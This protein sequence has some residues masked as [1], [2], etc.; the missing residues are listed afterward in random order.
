MADPITDYY[1][2]NP[3]VSIN[4][5]TFD[6]YVPALLDTF[7]KR[8]VYRNFV[9]Y[10]IDLGAQR[11]KKM[12]FTELFD[13]EPNTNAV[14]L[15]TLWANASHLDSR[16]VSVD[17]EYHMGKIAAHKYDVL[18]TQWLQAGGDLSSICRGAL[19]QML[20][21]HLDILARNAFIVWPFSLYSGNATNFQSIQ[22]TD[23]FD[24]SE[25]A[26][27]VWVHMAEKDL[28]LATDPMGDRSQML[29]CI[30]T[31]RVISDMR[32]NNASLW[33][34]V[35]I[36]S[37]PEMIVQ[38]EVG[39]LNNVRFVETNRN[40]LH[41]CGAIT[42]Q[43]AITTALNPGDGAATTVDTVYTVGQT[44]AADHIHLE[45]FN[46]GEYAVGDKVVIHRARTSSYGV[47]NGVDPKDGTQ[48]VRR[49]VA[50]DA[51]ANTISVD[52]PVL[53][54]FS[55]EVTSGVYG[56]VTKA[57]DIHMSI[58]LAGPSAVACGVGDPP[59]VYTPAPIDDVQGMYRFSYDMLLK[60]QAFRPE[61]AEVLFSTG[62]VD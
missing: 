51:T 23:K 5:N 47:T 32:R 43:K 46:S 25:L 20:T 26:E 19:G 8:S 35:G 40:V 1:S 38:N 42:T 44:G 50:V 31:P 10:Q 7:R 45:D 4:K 14:S 29:I 28:P 22:A 41:G 62:S 18:V 27:R 54:D 16:Q 55:T 39:L 49:I 13:A 21:D 36:Y 3:W 48:V 15:R 11:T 17:L 60:Y 61:F 12:I 37:R 59:K 6:T 24:D 30:T 52:K 2:D 34:S 57:R 33:R 58:F 56:W 53:K 9:N